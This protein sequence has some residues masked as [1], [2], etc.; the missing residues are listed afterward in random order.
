MPVEEVWVS[1][2]DCE[3]DCPYSVR[4]DPDGRFRFSDLASPARLRFDPL[5]CPDNDWECEPLEPREVER[6]SG[7]RTALGAKWPTGI[8]DT[9]LRYMPSVAGASISSEQARYR[10]SLVRQA[11]QAPKPCG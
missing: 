9:M 4:A 2:L 11:P 8:E 3:P 7:A 1:V 5:E 6:A 10:D